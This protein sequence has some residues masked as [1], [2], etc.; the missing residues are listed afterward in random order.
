[1][2]ADVRN[3]LACALFLSVCSDMPREPRGDA[4][5]ALD[6]A[7]AS[8]VQDATT[9]DGFESPPLVPLAWQYV[10][11]ECSIGLR[12][13][14]LVATGGDSGDYCVATFQDADCSYLRPNKCSPI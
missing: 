12:G 2:A 1:M 13:D 14:G 5:A 8:D 4:A 10:Y 9:D 3:V 11:G 6:D 7:G